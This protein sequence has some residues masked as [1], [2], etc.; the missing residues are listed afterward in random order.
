MFWRSRL[1][2]AIP[3]GAH[4]YSRGGDQYASLAPEI[5]VRG[6]G[7]YVWD[8]EGDKFLDYGMGL[9]SVILGYA[10]RSV[11]RAVIREIK[12]GNSLS[13]PSIT[14]LN[15]AERLIE[16]IPSAEM[17]K[18]AKNGSNVTSAASKMARAYT[19]R[20][21]ICV[22]NQQPFFSFDDWFIGSTAVKRGIPENYHELTLKFDY[23]SIDTL[24]ALFNKHTGE[25][26]AVMLEPATHLLPC[27]DSCKK[28]SGNLD[29]LA[30][31]NHKENFLKQV[32]AL[33]KRHGAVFILDEMRT[34]FR[35]HLRGAQEMY[36]VSPD[37]TT[38]GKALANGFSVA[39]LVGKREIMD[40]ASIDKVGTERVFLLSSTNGAEMSSLG[41]L[42][43]TTRQLESDKISEYLWDYGTKLRDGF[44]HL[45]KQAKV[46]Q[47]IFLDGPSVAL[48]LTALDINFQASTK[49]RT[50]FLQEMAK[51]HVLIASGNTFAPSFAHKERELKA[52]LDAFS[53][54]FLVYK[55][56][57]ER[58]IDLYLEGEEV[59]PVFRKYN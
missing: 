34:G 25:I 1:E 58:D 7:A 48:E 11:N 36:D 27:L 59:K 29:C 5:L 41:A 6:K 24:E 4:T 19:N 43:E 22:P 39:A 16:L 53:N 10:D 12:N 23:G 55:N 44:T 17:V 3:G 57:L 49:F 31:P 47:H 15:A 26:A 42:L 52:T 50:L 21:Y 9:R 54:S 32:Q 30:C 56:A 38:F 8:P 13:R 33:C 45:A 2:A 14:E 51:N 35:W 40:L 28:I 18:F 20:K 37:L 46:D